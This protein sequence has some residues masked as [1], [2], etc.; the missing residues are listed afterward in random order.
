MGMFDDLIP[1]SAPSGGMFADLIPKTPDVAT[2]VGKALVGNVL[3]NAPANLVPGWGA[4]TYPLQ[5][6]MKAGQYLGQNAVNLANYAT[7]QPQTSQSEFTQ[8]S[9]DLMNAITSKMGFGQ[10]NFSGNPS[11]Y[12][13]TPNVV[14]NAV[15]NAAGMP[16]YQPKT[17]VGQDVANIGNI[18]TGGRGA[19]AS[20]AQMLMGGIG[21][22]TGQ[23]VAKYFGGGEEPQFFAGLSGGFGGGAA[24]DKLNISGAIDKI[25]DA[26]IR[27]DT[28][29]NFGDITAPQFHD[30]AQRTF[31]L[32]DEKGGALSPQDTNKFI[33]SLSS[34]A[35]GSQ[36]GN[37]FRGSENPLTQKSQNME[38]WRDRSLTFAGATDIDNQ[39]TDLINGEKNQDGTLT[40]QGEQYLKVQD[41]LRELMTPSESGGDSGFDIRQQAMGTWSQ[42]RSLKDIQKIIDDA[43]GAPNPSQALM[44]GFRTLSKNAKRMNFFPE[45]EQAAIR[46]AAT[47]GLSGRF[48]NTFGSKLLGPAI[49]SG[50]GGIVG[51]PV[52]IGLGGAI[53]FGVA[54]ASS[55]MA[56]KMQMNRAGGVADLI[57]NRYDL[58][59][60]NTQPQTQPLMLPPPIMNVPPGGYNAVPNMLR[61]MQGGQ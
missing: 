20:G 32:A 11:D 8:N 33:D 54:D 44:S 53:G 17:Q 34:T 2:D 26:P 13:P 24:A 48:F 58:P 29:A 59:N 38:V 6:G 3:P 31:D 50:I 41:N 16:L 40:T 52:G 60:L 15:A 5:L 47:R 37:I 39:L 19:G 61:I 57:R 30:I 55:N 36:E 45:N 43:Q 4:V 27:P 23:D 1:T 7:G 35:R 21:A 51:G 49:A 42:Y 28:P 10:T 46:D 9:K 14:T 12:V 18:M 22:T 56:A 25:Q